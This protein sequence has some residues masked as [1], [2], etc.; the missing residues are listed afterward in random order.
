MEQQENKGYNGRH[1]VEDMTAVI[2][3]AFDFQ[4]PFLRLNS[5]F[6]QRLFVKHW[7]TIAEGLQSI[8][9]ITHT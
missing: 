9:T 5:Y 2:R 3:I 7:Q 6:W 1:N 4:Y 8:E